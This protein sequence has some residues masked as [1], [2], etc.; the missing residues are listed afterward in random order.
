MLQR[1]WCFKA[2]RGGSDDR[3]KLRAL[4]YQIQRPPEEAQMKERWSILQARTLLEKHWPAYEAL[5][6][7]MGHRT[8][9][10]ECRQIISAHSQT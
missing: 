4:Y 2:E 3:Q 5:V 7:A 10:D 8:S 9:V 1:R 6:I